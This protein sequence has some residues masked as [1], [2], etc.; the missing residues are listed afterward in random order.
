MANLSKNEKKSMRYG[1]VVVVLIFL[2]NFAANYPQY[3]LSP[4]AYLLMPQLNLSAAQFSQ[5]FSSSM[6]PGILLGI[7]SGL[8]CDRFGTKKCIA[9]AGALSVIGIVGRIFA[10]SFA[11]MFLCMLLIG[12][13][14]SFV[15]S[16]LAKIVGTWFP[17]EKV[18]VM[19]GIG[20]AGSTCSMAVAM[21][22][23]AMLPGVKFAFT[24][25]AVFMAGVLLL[26]ILLMKENPE[27]T[28]AET[29]QKDIP[30]VSIKECVFKL[31]KVRHIWVIGLAIG[32]VLAGSMCLSTFLPSALQSVRGFSAEAAG[33]LSSV[34][35]FGSLA[36]TIIGPILCAKIGKM[37]PFLIV[38]SLITALGFGAAWLAPEGIAMMA[39]LFCTGFISSSVITLLY[40]VPV[41]LPQVGVAYAGTA[42]GIVATIQLICGVGIPSYV[43]T[44]LI[45]GNF[46]LLFLVG[47]ALSLVAALLILTL[48]EVYT[49]K[50]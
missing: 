32:M 9:I 44:P 40:S 45:G 21:G 33:G 19:V 12:V 34:I 48:P 20:M 18:S 35:T 6:I 1:Y 13:I 7:V 24:V 25:A 41:M 37:K 14:A 17:P 2:F 4:L 5:L 22:T 30:A 3:Q 16:N 8:L 29:E 15:N 36:G 23:T 49:A 43:L 50:K 27:D 26:W 42:G 38:S 47:G 11:T 31:V 39:A 28:S 10:P 46:T